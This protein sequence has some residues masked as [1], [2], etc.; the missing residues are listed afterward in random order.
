MITWLIGENTFEVKEALR[1]LEHGFSGTPEYVDGDTLTLAQLPDLLMGMSLFSESRLVVIRDITANTTLWEKLSDWLPRIND[2]I[3][4]VF[5]DTKPDKRTS[6]YKALKAAANVQEFAP[7]TE[8]D[9]QKAEK[10]VIDRAKHEGFSLASKEAKHLVA[11]VGTD[12][13]QLA[14]AVERLAL[15]DTISVEKIDDV[16]PSSPS[17]NVFQLFELAL[18]GKRAAL[19]ESIRTLSSYEDPYRLFGLL[20]S[21]VLSLAAVTN[22]SNDDTPEKDFAIHPFVASKLARHGKKLGPKKVHEIVS[23]AAKADAGMK[24]SKADPWLLV[25]QFLLATAHLV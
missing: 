16:I 4:I 6:A 12:Q 25:E 5:I 1:K 14:Q 20:V 18:D 10:W 2:D 3:H 22:A 7:W 11:R 13:W 15:L 21:Q 9:Y 19:A 17:E 23:L 24:R 8:R